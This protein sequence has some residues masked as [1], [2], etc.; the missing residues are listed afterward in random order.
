MRFDLI[1]KA[2]IS[3]DNL[4]FCYS[5]SYIAQIVVRILEEHTTLNGLESGVNTSKTLR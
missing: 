5:V 3:D 2:L 4:L 1:N